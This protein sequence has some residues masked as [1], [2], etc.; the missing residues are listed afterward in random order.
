MSGVME[1]ARTDPATGFGN[2]AAM[3]LASVVA[4]ARAQRAGH[5]CAVA[6]VKLA[7][8]EDTWARDQSIS[9]A[10]RASLRATDQI[11][12]VDTDT[13][14]ALLPMAAGRGVGAVMDRAARLTDR[15]FM[16]GAAFAGLDG[17]TTGELVERATGR[18]RASR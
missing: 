13:L 15:P 9:I 7:D 5:S 16:W 6:V 10:M 18:L 12:R 3:H 8:A 11:F 4:M 14:V 17:K 2:R 1:G